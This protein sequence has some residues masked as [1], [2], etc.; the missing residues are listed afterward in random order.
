LGWL[1]GALYSLLDMAPPK[2]SARVAAQVQRNVSKVAALVSK[3]EQEIG[4]HQRFVERLTARLGHPSTLYFIVAVV[5]LWMAWNT[6]GRRWGIAPFDPPPFTWLQGLITLCALLMTTMV[7]TTQNRQALHAEQR[8]HLDLQVNLLGEQ[9]AAKLISLLE[10]L[11]RDLPSV[12]NRPDQVAEAMSSPVE[13]EAVLSA[14]EDT[15][16]KE[17]E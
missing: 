6:L 11:R 15:L 3:A 12:P 5:G 10:E 13:P 17:D 4:Q 8:S 9:K 1:G 7:L 14:L 16:A 2:K